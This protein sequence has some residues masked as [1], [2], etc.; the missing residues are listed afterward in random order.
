MQRIRVN[1]ELLQVI[2][3]NFE[4]IVKHGGQF[5]G[6]DG[7]RAGDGAHMVDAGLQIAQPL[8]G[9]RTFG[10]KRGNGALAFAEV[11]SGI[12]ACQVT[13]GVEI[14]IATGIRTGIRTGMRQGKRRRGGLLN[15]GLFHH[16]FRP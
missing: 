10:N 12:A 4:A 3:E 5:A 1:I 15:V 6:G 8:C 16:V 13:P 2:G 11:C 9:L 7:G 14:E